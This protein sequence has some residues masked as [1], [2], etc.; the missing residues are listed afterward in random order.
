MISVI[1]PT[2]N[3]A[4]SVVK[5]IESA[6]ASQNVNT[7]IIV[8]DDGSTDDTKEVLSQYDG[9][10][11]VKVIYQKNRGSNPTRNRGYDES[12]GEYLI[13]LDADAVLEPDALSQLKNVLRDSK[14]SFSYSDFRF[15]WKLFKTGE[16]DLERLR[17]MNYIHTSSLIK[18]EDFP[19]FDEAIKRFQ[20]WD[21][22]L[23]MAAQG[24]TGVYVPGEL[25]SMTVERAG[26]SS[27]LPKSW[28]K[29][30]W[31]WLPWIALRVKKYEDAKQIIKAKHSL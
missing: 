9:N 23:T 29:A 16:Y 24:K 25:M 20:D 11:A 15:G 1:I 22:W 21:L 12:E 17:K 7:E 6:L 19:K 26:I 13:F 30:P 2:Y 31:K 14:A 4:S 8:I 5:T 10:D 27:W 18:R 28:Y 3:H